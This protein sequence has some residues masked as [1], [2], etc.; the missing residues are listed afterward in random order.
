MNKSLTW[1]LAAVAWVVWLPASSIPWPLWNYPAVG[2]GIHY[3]HGLFPSGNSGWSPDRASGLWREYGNPWEICRPESVRRSRSTATWNRLC[4][5]GGL[6]K[7]WHAGRKIKGPW[8]IPVVG[9]GGHTVNILRLWESRASEF[10]FDWDVFNAGGYIDSPGREGPAE[11]ISKVL[12]PNDGPTQARAA[13][14]PAVLLLRL[15][16]QGTSC[17]ATSGYMAVTSA[18]L[19]RKSPS[20]SNDTHPTVAIPELMRVLVDEEG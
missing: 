16:H 14:D 8:D 3:E 15:L 6:K 7:V 11:T 18:T 19:P 5:K 9:F 20:S 4:D 10:F 2:Y 12:Y 1:P 17:V 13:P